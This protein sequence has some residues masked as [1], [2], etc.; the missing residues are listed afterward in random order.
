LIDREADIINFPYNTD[1]QDKDINIITNANRSDSLTYKVI[2]KEEP[3]FL[4]LKEA[5]E[6]SPDHDFK[7]LGIPSESWLGVPLKT[8]GE[9]IGAMV[10]QS[11]DD[12]DRYTKRDVEILTSVSDY[13]V[14]VIER[15]E[16]EQALKTSRKRY[17][18]LVENLDEVIFTTD[19]NGIIN[20][21]SPSVKQVTGFTQK[22]IVGSAT[23]FGDQPEIWPNNMPLIQGIHSEDRERLR[24]TVKKLWRPA[25][26]TRWEMIVILWGGPGG[27]VAAVRAASL[28][29]AAT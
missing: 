17:R 22:E 15:K 7:M 11:Y 29:A 6:N 4:K 1:K 12:P 8:K 20:Y 10:V 23:N 18:H 14:V 27:Y 3:L 16:T 9:T 25:R 19:S 28:G 5:V 24:R 13:V 2:K 21:I 26:G